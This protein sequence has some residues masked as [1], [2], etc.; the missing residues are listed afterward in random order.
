MEL[1][2]IIER[3]YQLFSNYQPGDYL[4]ACT[5]CCME[6][7]NEALLKSLPLR[8]VTWDLIKDYQDAAKPEILNINELKYFAPKYFELISQYEY[9]SFE[10]L[11]SLSRFGYF[12]PTDWKEEEWQLFMDFSITF[13]MNYFQNKDQYFSVPILDVLL[14]FHKANFPLAPLLSYW[15]NDETADSLHHLNY[16]MDNISDKRKITDAF[17][18]DIFDKKICG[19]LFSD[20]ILDTFKHRIENIIMHPEGHDA[21][22]I[23]KLNWNY[24]RLNV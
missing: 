3:A 4:D 21:I 18:D 7:Q 16:L 1:K 2:K 19:W 20:K 10:P 5:H 8:T 22:F 14:M 9:P 17:S 12:N 13:F 11:L 15:E 6:P 24:E 23:Q